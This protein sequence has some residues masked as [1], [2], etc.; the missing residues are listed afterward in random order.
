LAC[1]GFSGAGGR[2]YWVWLNGKEWVFIGLELKCDEVGCIFGSG[3][4]ESTKHDAVAAL[5]TRS[6][7]TVRKC[8]GPKTVHC[9]VS[10]TSIPPLCFLRYVME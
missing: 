7:R 2:A 3:D 9:T 8:H 1:E 5:V 4:N 10:Y 6:Y